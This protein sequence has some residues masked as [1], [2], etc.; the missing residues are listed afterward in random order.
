MPYA[1]N[2]WIRD[3]GCKNRIMIKFYDNLCNDI[4]DRYKSLVLYFFHKINIIL[5]AS[6]CELQFFWICWKW[7]E[8]KYWVNHHELVVSAMTTKIARKVDLNTDPVA[9]TYK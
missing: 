8:M 6:L 5:Y 7:E 4:F 1:Y 9:P 2:N 3:G